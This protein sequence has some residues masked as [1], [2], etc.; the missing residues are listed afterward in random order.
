VTSHHAYG[1]GVYSY[2]RDNWVTVASGIKAPSR[3]GVYFHNSLSV[4]LNG[5]GAIN[6]VIN[7]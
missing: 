1:V 5:N 6:H 2:F 3:S 4:F 7:D